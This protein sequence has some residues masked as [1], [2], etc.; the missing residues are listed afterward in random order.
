MLALCLSFFV[1]FRVQIALA[2]P[3][4]EDK[5]ATA[6]SETSLLSEPVEIVIHP[7]R[8]D[9]LVGEAESASEG[10][11]GKE[12]FEARP[13]LRTG[14]VIEAV[15]G[16]IATQHAGGGKANQ[17]F[18]RGFN[19][20]HGTD[21]RTEVDGMPVNLVTHGHGQG[22]TDL[23][24]LIPEL[25]D[26]I[27][28]NKGLYTAEK[29]DFATAGS[30]EFMLSHRLSTP[31]AKVTLGENDFARLFSAGSFEFGGG[32][33]LGAIELQN[34]DGP[35]IEEQDSRRLNGVLRY[36]KEDARETFNVMLMAYRGTW[37]SSDQIPQRAVENGTLP[38]LG[39]VDP[40]TG[41]DSNRF[42]P[43]YELGASRDDWK[44]QSL[45]VCDLLRSRSLF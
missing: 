20:D 38:R 24:F 2:Q 44:L 35:W 41:G 16:I 22:Y 34:Y 40:T 32:D 39:T 15:P 33:L 13:I 36:S 29:G 8:Y 6:E 25:V 19:L 1:V 18:F 9:D 26:H 4:S 3:L 21:F 28:Y 11:V 43:L 7:S 23:N 5:Q 10:H 45:G 17:Y 27:D 37:N 14:E 12:V 30:A 42:S 31:I